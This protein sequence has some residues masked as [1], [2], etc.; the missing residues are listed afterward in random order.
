M[1]NSRYRSILM[2]LKE[3]D[4]KGIVGGRGRSI[5]GEAEGGY[6][7]YPSFP[8]LVIFKFLGLVKH[9]QKQGLCTNVVMS[10][11]ICCYA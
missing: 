10:P 2:L 8:D 4:R 9:Y 3:C 7:S 6:Y 1:I 11:G 5:S